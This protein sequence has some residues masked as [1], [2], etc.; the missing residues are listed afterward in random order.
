MSATKKPLTFNIGRS[1]TTPTERQ[2]E[3]KDEAAKPAPV[4]EDRKQVGARITA[5]TYRQLKA[6]AAMQGGKVQDLVE[7]AITEFLENHPA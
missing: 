6:R 2:G 5:A 3:R 4:A 1:P 7:L